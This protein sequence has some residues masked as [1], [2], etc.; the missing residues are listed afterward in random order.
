VAVSYRSACASII[1]HGQFSL[2]D[3]SLLPTAFYLFIM[4]D[5]VLRGN[6]SSA[7]IKTSI[8]LH[9]GLAKQSKTRTRRHAP[10]QLQVLPNNATRAPATA[11]LNAGPIG[12]YITRL[13]LVIKFAKK[14]ACLHTPLEERRRIKKRRP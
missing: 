10:R 7:D 2:H 3:I 12:Y 13:S 1:D 8:T 5:S 11:M 6:N 4:L 14:H 9:S